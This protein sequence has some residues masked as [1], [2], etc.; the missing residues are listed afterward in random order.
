MSAA[1]TSPEV[2]TPI[3]PAFYT[4]KETAQRLNLSV[5]RLYELLADGT[6][7][8]R[9]LGGKTVIRVDELEQYIADLPLA[10]YGQEKAGR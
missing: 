3:Q 7:M 8:A 5:A 9:K 6:L 10:V 1:P 4:V 2:A